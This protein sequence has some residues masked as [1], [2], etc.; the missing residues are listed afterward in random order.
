MSDIKWREAVEKAEAYKAVGQTSLYIERGD[1]PPWG[2]VT[3][4]GDGASHRL[5][6]PVSITFEADHPCGLTFK[7]FWDL[8]TRDANGRGGYQIDAPNV[9]RTLGRLAESPALD[10][11]VAYLERVANAIQKQGDES[12]AFAREQYAQERL[13][14]AL[15]ATPVVLPEGT[16]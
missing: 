8:E 13:L 1:D 12:L 11:F 14:R 4:V 15:I 7:W 6:I 16:P 3:R 5:D 9:V 10:D 2:F